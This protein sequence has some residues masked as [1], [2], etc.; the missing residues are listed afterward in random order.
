[1]AAAFDAV[2]TVQQIL[3]MLEQQLVVVSLLR[4]VVDRGLQVA[5]GTETG[6]EPL[7]DCSLVVAPYTVDGEGGLHRG[8]RPDPHELPRGPRRRRRREPPARAAA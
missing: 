1:M 2:E 3:R 8:P 6:I 4:D 5:I 7:A